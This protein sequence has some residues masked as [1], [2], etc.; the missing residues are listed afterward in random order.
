MKGTISVKVSDSRVRYSFELFRNIT[1]VQGNSGTGKTTLFDMISAY[2]RL[3][4]RSGVQIVCD[5]PCVALLADADWQA[6]LEK[7]SGSIVFIDEDAEYIGMRVFASAIRHTDNYYVIFSREPMHELPYSVN[8]IYEIKT[9]GKY[10]TFQKLYKPLKGCVYVKA[11][12]SKKSEVVLTEDAK[13]GYQFYQQ[14]YD[15]S[16][17]Q[18]ETA[19]SN[20]GIFAWLKTHS[21]KKVFVV[22]DGAAFGSEMDRIMKL[23]HQ[24]PNKITICLPE[25]FEW[26][27]LQ[28][29]LISTPG[30]AEMLK[31]PGSSIDS[32]KYFSW[33]NFFEDYL[34]QNTKDS[35]FAYSKSKLHSFY[36]IRENS[37]KIIALVAVN[38]PKPNHEEV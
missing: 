28:S 20:S 25:S 26:L 8:E 6:R 4:D 13:S 31:D 24:Y 12:E 7:T 33:E 1:V 38:M 35:Y 16:S 27:I 3:K 36:T 15:G 34:I 19:G 23:Q 17:V 18:C 2:T 32:Q 30:V 37:E 29:G 21:E 22:A 9:S 5:H 11:A 10:H 14:Y